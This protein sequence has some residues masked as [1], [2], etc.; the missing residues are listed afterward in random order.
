[1][2]RGTKKGRRG[3][4]L[5]TVAVLAYSLITLAPMY[6]V[7]T[8][9]FKD[10][11]SIIKNPFFAELSS[12][13]IEPMRE[14][15]DLLDYPTTFMNNIRLL[16]ISSVI[17]VVCASMA[18]YAIATARS[19]LLDFYYLLLIGV[20]TLPFLLA[21]VPLVLLLNLL[22]LHDS[23][24]GTSLVYSA[25]TMAFG[26][27]LYTGYM[28]GLPKELYE[29]AT[30]D[31]CGYF[32]KYVRIY[33]PL[34]KTITG[35]VIMLRSVFFWNDYIIASTT[36]TKPKMIPLML[37]LYAFSSNRLTRYDLLFAGTLLVS[38]PIMILFI[39]TQRVFVSGITAGAVKG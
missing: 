39:F 13:T 25:C 32:Q 27:F 29:A 35:T 31:G 33:M 28:R 19:K 12:L 34:L 10:N 14:T 8:N 7:I 17:L 1:M 26:T 11:K 36:L 37:K 15:F 24:I 4:A 2:G 22:K 3:R 6:F 9:A 30:V 16:L 21:M 20:Q 18:G 23:F 38:L 5:M